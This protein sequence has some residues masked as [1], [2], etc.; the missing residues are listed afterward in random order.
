MYGVVWC[1]MVWMDVRRAQDNGI[2]TELL[3]QSSYGVYL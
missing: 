2:C 3:Q 1:G